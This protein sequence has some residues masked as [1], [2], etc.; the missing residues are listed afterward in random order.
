MHGVTRLTMH[1]Q[2][3]RT[4]VRP[5]P[6]AVVAQYRRCRRTCA[7]C[8]AGGRHGPYFVRYW[9]DAAGK[10]HQE[11]IR[12]ARVADVRRQC[13]AWRAQRTTRQALARM[14]LGDWRAGRALLR[15]VER[16]IGDR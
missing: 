3:K 14:A 7:T 9:R 10:A 15:E 6:G 11:Y 16:V 5:L 2:H 8:A 1:T 4:M 13:A 12:P